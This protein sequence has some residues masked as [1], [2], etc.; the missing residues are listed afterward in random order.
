[1][2]RFVNLYVKEDETCEVIFD[3][4]HASQ[5]VTWKRGAEGNGVGESLPNEFKR[6]WTQKKY[7]H[8]VIQSTQNW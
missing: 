7:G 5:L 6:K 1:M 4:E 3:L 2:I 8:R